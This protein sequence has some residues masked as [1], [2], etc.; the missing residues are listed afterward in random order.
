MWCNCYWHPVFA[1]L[2]VALRHCE[3][4]HQPHAVL[5]TYRY[6]HIAT[7]ITRDSTSCCPSTVQLW[8]GVL[9]AC[10]AIG[11]LAVCL[12]GSLGAPQLT[13]VIHKCIQSTLSRQPKV[14]PIHLLHTIHHLETCIAAFTT[15][16][17][18]MLPPLHAAIC[19]NQSHAP[20]TITSVTYPTP[21]P[22]RRQPAA[23]PVRPSRHQP[24]RPGCTGSGSTCSSSS[25]GL[26]GVCQGGSWLH[27]C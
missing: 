14:S 25:Q 15:C 1:R 5:P 7:E 20:L 26:P 13:L 24:P 2:A 10:S 12:S 22:N 21:L 11:R 4:M 9:C 17:C 8:R 18:P 16:P 19:M 6:T 27:P 23:C 3:H